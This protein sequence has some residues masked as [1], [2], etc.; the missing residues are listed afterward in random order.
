MPE[1]TGYDHGV[2]SWV[3]MGAADPNAARNFYS[4]LF[5][6]E[7]QD[8]GEESG[9]YHMMT[10]GGQMVAGVGPAQDP[11]PPRWAM[12]VNVDDVDEVAKA[13]EA[14]G[15]KV[16]VAPMDVMS[17]GRMLVFADP[18]GAIVSAWQPR[19][20]RGAQL[21][22]E[23]GAFIWSELHTSDLERAKQF[24]GD[25]FGWG[26]GGAPEYAEVQVNGRSVAAAMARHPEMPAEVPDN[27]LIYFGSE[28]VDAD[29]AKASGLGA[30]VTVPAT[31]IPN[32][33]RFAVLLDPQGGAF[34][35]YKG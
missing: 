8:M 1:M 24:Y 6:W 17:A 2:P 27:W 9:H 20:H 14:N 7:G 23:A 22:N 13:V 29:V 16:L 10:K 35:I 5:G 3:D 18:T 32:M 15:G 25:V 26:W 28:D 31:D 19:D 12:Y 34:A 30:R 11:G 33:G 21:V 4:Q